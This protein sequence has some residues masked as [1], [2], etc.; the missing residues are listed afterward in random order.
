M[1]TIYQNVP[2]VYCT[3]IYQY[4]CMHINAGFII[5]YF[6]KDCKPADYFLQYSIDS[7]K[8]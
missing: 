5:Y 8:L 1:K 7:E 6:V 2:S 4:P 3:I